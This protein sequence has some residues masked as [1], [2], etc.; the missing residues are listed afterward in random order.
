MHCVESTTICP[1][2]KLPDRSQTFAQTPPDSR[3]VQFTPVPG[4]A[5]R[6]NTDGTDRRRDRADL[7]RLRALHTL[8]GMGEG[9][10]G[11]GGGDGI[12]GV[13]YHN[14]Y[15]GRAATSSFDYSYSFSGELEQEWRWSERYA[16]QPEIPALHQPRG[17]PLRPARDILLNNLRCR[18]RLRRV[19][20]PLDGQRRG[21]AAG[22]GQHL[23][24]CVGQLSTQDARLSR[25]GLSLQGRSS[26]AATGPRTCRPERP[27]RRHHRHRLVG[28]ADD[29]GDRPGGSHSDRVPAHAQ[30][31]HPA[32]NAPVT[33]EEDRQVKA[34]YGAPR[35]G[36][37]LAHR[38]GLH[39]QPQVGAGSQP[40]GA[41]AGHEAAWNRLGFGFAL[42]YHDIPAGQ[43]RQR[44][45]GRVH[46]AARSARS[47]TT[48]WCAKLIPRNHAFAARRPSVDSGYFRRSTGPTSSWPTCA[49]RPS[50][51]HARG[52]PHLR[53][54]T[55]PST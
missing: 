55:T 49:R 30:L 41:R 17:R 23:V 42:A 53:N 46:P 19:A 47:S 3:A 20:R 43:G 22:D 29:A 33:D 31:Q 15:P 21:A 5:Q 25:A 26:T 9:P 10:G 51:F 6:S 52:H 39:A 44:H 28:H 50:S 45:G 34:K 32:A 27:A 14:G 40:G 4:P 2:A 24:L 35:P 37:E 8:R 11:A 18:A 7:R 54:R 38:P 36:L 12:G 16:T 1:V 13:W 48:R